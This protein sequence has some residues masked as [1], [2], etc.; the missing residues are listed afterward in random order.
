MKKVIL[1]LSGFAVIHSC[2]KNDGKQINVENR[3][4]D[5]LA[6]P[7]NE[8]NQIATT[9]NVD[10][11]YLNVL[12]KDSMIL[13]YKIVNG[14]VSGKLAYK[15]FEKDSSTGDVSGTVA[16]DTLK[17]NYKYMSEGTTSEREVYFLQ[18]SGVLLEGIGNYSDNSSPKQ[19]YVSSKAVN[20][21]KGRRLT[22]ADCKEFK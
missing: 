22:P 7:K 5:T 21:S 2:E 13:S 17:L 19:V 12:A 9:E 15:N 18:D 6:I 11:C 3:K 4:P 8:K 14:Q 16:G 10:Y 20:Y 1:I